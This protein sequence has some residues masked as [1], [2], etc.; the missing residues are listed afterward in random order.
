MFKTIIFVV[1]QQLG[2]IHADLK[3]ENIM[4]VDPVRQP[5]RVK[6]IDFGSAS[7]VSKAVCSTYLQSRYYRAPEIIL[8][9]PF[10]EAIDMWSLG[11]VIAE[12]FLGWPLYPGSSEYDQIRYISQTQGVPADHMLNNATKTSR[13]FYRENDSN[14]PFWRL[15]NP[16]EHEAETNIKSKE[17][18]KYIF[19]CLDDMAQ[20]NVP[21]DVEGLELQAEKYDR[22]EFIDLLK[23]MLTLDQERRI[24]PGEAL[25]HN[26]VTLQ[27]LNP[28]FANCSNV[29]SSIQMMSVADRRHSGSSRYNRL[30]N[31]SHHHSSSS[32]LIR[33]DALNNN[34]H[35]HHSVIS[36]AVG[37][38][39]SNGSSSSNNNSNHN[40]HHHVSSG[41]HVTSSGNN[42]NPHLADDSPTYPHHHNSSGGNSSNG[43]TGH[44]HHG[45]QNSSSQNQLHIPHD[46]QHSAA[47]AAAAAAVHA[48]SAALMNPASNLTLTFNPVSG[49]QLPPGYA[50]LAAAVSGQHQNPHHHLN[51]HHPVLS[52]FYHQVAAAASSNPS[53]GST[54]VASSNHRINAGG[55]NRHHNNHQSSNSH[56]HQSNHQS[57]TAATTAQVA[58]VNAQI[59]ALFGHHAVSSAV[60]G[61]NPHHHHHSGTVGHNNSKNSGAA[62]FN[63]NHQVPVQLPSTLLQAASSQQQYVPVAVQWPP[64]P[65]A[66]VPNITGAGGP[67]LFRDPS[68]IQP[69]SGW[70][71]PFQ[72][73]HAASNMQQTQM[74][75]GGTSGPSQSR[76]PWYGLVTGGTGG[77][78]SSTSG[79]SSAAAEAWYRQIE[80]ERQAMLQAAGVVSAAGTGAADAAAMGIMAD[81]VSWSMVPHA[82]A[83]AASGQVAPGSLQPPVSL[84][85]GVSIPHNPNPAHQNQLSHVHHSSSSSSAHV[86]PHVAHVH[87][88]PSTLHQNTQLA[89]AGSSSSSGL[90]VSSHHH[91]NPHHHNSSHPHMSHPTQI[92]PAHGATLLAALPSF[93][94]RQAMAS[95]AAVISMSGGQVVDPKRYTDYL[96]TLHAAVDPMRHHPAVDQPPPFLWL[97]TTV[98]PNCPNPASLKSPDDILLPH[99]SLTSKPLQ[100][101]RSHAS[102]ST[103]SSRN[104][105][106]T[107]GSVLGMSGMSGH[108]AHPRLQALHVNHVTTATNTVP[109]QIQTVE[110]STGCPS[111]SS[112]SSRYHHQRTRDQGSS[113]LS[114]VK[115]R[116]KESSPPKWGPHDF[117]IR[118]PTGGRPFLPESTAAGYISGPSSAAGLMPGVVGATGDYSPAQSTMSIF[119]ADPKQEYGVQVPTPVGSNGSSASIS[120]NSLNNNGGR[121]GTNRT[122]GVIM[123]SSG[124][125]NNSFGGKN[126]LEVPT[127][128]RHQSTGGR[129]GHHN[130]NNSVSCGHPSCQHEANNNNIYHNSSHPTITLDDTPSPAVSVITISDSSEGEEQSVSRNI[131]P[132]W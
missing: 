100:K 11:C 40:L 12:L 84:S 68:S 96:S 26:F 91:F 13:F 93:K 105:M 67:G 79:T 88:N 55:S 45:I 44:L 116:V 53:G 86:N 112:S 98:A 18:R 131:T 19:N 73:A 2:L 124:H 7:H 74:S 29:K 95:D 42:N 78:S 111:G 35:G 17:A 115:K 70:P 80:N 60:A 69:G 120:H 90:G 16:D 41:T 132:A 24:T 59:A 72:V 129:S 114:P 43:S 4:L 101:N 77:S 122:S 5:F 21:N 82:V 33:S 75:S 102:T 117:I 119:A 109:V 61:F 23:R 66:T 57:V 130:Q 1:M 31:S 63:P 51:Q 10:C 110:S 76:A 30:N 8:G 32:T 49:V 22:R 121:S 107:V 36:N 39:G 65:Q 58:A 87:H 127:I 46:N 20:V 123:R 6:V 126:R 54:S 118:T 38:S 34:H 37:T 9:L 56:N 14:Y 104:Q 62:L 128:S 81:L 71:G 15:K 108:M 48:A 52:S 92:P 47:A 50:H 85:S 27:H 94:R 99:G 83:A 113:Q 103:C 25:N 28:D 97:D 3:P 64:A 125:H 106:M 89:H